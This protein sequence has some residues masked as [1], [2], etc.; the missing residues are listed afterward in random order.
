MKWD[1]ALS[2]ITLYPES[3]TSAPLDAMFQRQPVETGDELETERFLVQIDEPCSPPNIPD[4]KT[5]SVSHPNSFAPY[6][7]ALKTH[8]TSQKQPPPTNCSLPTYKR[9]RFRAPHRQQS[10][11]TTLPSIPI[12]RSS[13]AES[14]SPL[15]V[16]QTSSQFKTPKMMLGESQGT[17]NS[18]LSS[19]AEFAVQQFQEKSIYMRHPVK[20]TKQSFQFNVFHDE[21]SMET[22]VESSSVYGGETATLP[23]QNRSDSAIL[24]LLLGTAHTTAESDRSPDS[25]YQTNN[26]DLHTK[27][28]GTKDTMRSTNLTSTKCYP[29][30]TTN[31]RFQDHNDDCVSAPLNTKY[32]IAD[33]NRHL[34]T[35]VYSN[36]Q[37]QSLNDYIEKDSALRNLGV[38]HGIPAEQPSISNFHDYSGAGRDA[39]KGEQMERTTSVV[40]RERSVTGTE[41]AEFLRDESEEDPWDLGTIMGDG[42]WE[43]WEDDNDTGNRTNVH[44]FSSQCPDKSDNL[45]GRAF[46]TVLK[47][48]FYAKQNMVSIDQSSMHS[49]TQRD[50]EFVAPT[51][52]LGSKILFI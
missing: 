15:I 37:D 19:Q 13:E 12:K 2:K 48:A 35:Y 29:P 18:A 3:S 22:N 21:L 45:D 38:G 30:A 49:G 25:R 20:A 52:R 32:H 11:P 16:E 23:S 33:T 34:E 8:P 10:Q 44:K 1:P 7:N 6:Q 39:H 31:L 24:A 46:R 14:N 28:Q 4:S 40:R 17:T 26:N 47:D 42:V 9:P 27:C 36:E 5:T 41:G 51:M 50:V 43:V